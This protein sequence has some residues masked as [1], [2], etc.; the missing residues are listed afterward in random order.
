MILDVS[1]VKQIS[2]SNLIYEKSLL[3]QRNSKLKQHITQMDK[4]LDQRKV[5]LDHKPAAEPD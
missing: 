3:I 1:K 2:I 4:D 5:K